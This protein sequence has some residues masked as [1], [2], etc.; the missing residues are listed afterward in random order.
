[1]LRQRASYYGS[2]LVALTCYSSAYAFNLCHNNHE[3]TQQSNILFRNDNNDHRYYESRLFS[4][5]ADSSSS[6]SDKNDD[7]DNDEEK[8]ASKTIRNSAFTRNEFSRIINIDRIFSNRRRAL[9]Q[10]QRDHVVTVKADE[11]ERKALAER[12]DLKGLI[13]LNAELSFRPAREGLADIGYGGSF[14]VEAEGMIEA[15]L[16]QTCVRTNEEF[17]VD[18]EIPV[19]AIIRPV[20]SNFEKLNG[21]NTQ[22]EQQVQE[23][24][25]EEESNTKGKKKNKNK[26]KKDKNTFHENKKVYNLDDIFNLQTALQE[27]DSFSSGGAGGGSGIGGSDDE[28]GVADVVEDEGI[29]SL[30]SD[31]L[32]VGELIAQTFWLELDWYPKKPGTGPM[33]FEISG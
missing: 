32:D 18:V 16:T 5:A 23:E 26:K 1:M 3:R 19:Y 17:D 14:P 27:A 15:H 11:N 6:S 30:S 24:E 4:S 20:E 22:T 7:I 8:S 31:Q 9:N 33:E 2:C 10:S 29:Y 25:E 21:I 12:F 13:K 28:D